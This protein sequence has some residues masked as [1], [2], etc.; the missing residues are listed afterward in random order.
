MEMTDEERITLARKAMAAATEAITK[1]ESSIKAVLI[2]T[3][4]YGLFVTPL[5]MT[6]E[7]TFSLLVAACS[8][9]EPETLANP[10]GEVH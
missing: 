9:L 7:E 2:A 3:D 8:A 4:G 1:E 5:R 10:S 6:K